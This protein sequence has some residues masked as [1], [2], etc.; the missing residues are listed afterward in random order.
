MP[1]SSRS[2]S[3]PDPPPQI[4]P[5]GATTGDNQMTSKAAPIGG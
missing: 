3:S 4:H 5:F 1:A 2:S